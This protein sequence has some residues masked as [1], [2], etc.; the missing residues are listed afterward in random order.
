[1]VKD[2]AYAYITAAEIDIVY[3]NTYKHCIYKHL[4]DVITMSPIAFAR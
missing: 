2:T 1:M 3:I 4:H